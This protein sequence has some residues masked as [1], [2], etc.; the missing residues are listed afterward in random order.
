M[1]A[2]A[3][4]DSR[5]VAEQKTFVVRPEGKELEDVVFRDGVLREIAELGGGTYREASL[6]GVT[7]RE[8]QEIRVGSQHAI[9]VWSNPLFLLVA[10]GL[11]AAEWTLRRRAGFR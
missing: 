6:D 8:P 2:S 1:T 5:A 11:L 10:L 7:I 4:L 3:S 9:A